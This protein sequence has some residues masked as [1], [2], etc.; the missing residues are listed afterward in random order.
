M[1]LP[2]NFQAIINTNFNNQLRPPGQADLPP[3]ANENYSKS[4][5]F[6]TLSLFEKCFP[7][8][9][10][11]NRKLRINGIYFVAALE[12]DNPID[13]QRNRKFT[14]SNSNKSGIFHLLSKLFKSGL[15]EKKHN[16]MLT[17]FKIL[18]GACIYRQSVHFWLFVTR[19][20]QS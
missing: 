7:N 20:N 10:S 6:A 16:I 1:V 4:S 18:C 15:F 9:E 8:P 14:I 17:A 13:C 11:A 5:K 19:K 2:D 12:S 3:G